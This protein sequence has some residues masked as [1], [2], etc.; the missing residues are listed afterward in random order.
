MKQL[1]DTQ[2]STVMSGAQYNQQLRRL[3]SIQHDINASK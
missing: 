3:C 2:S 1:E